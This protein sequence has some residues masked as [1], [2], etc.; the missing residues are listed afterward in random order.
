MIEYLA[1]AFLLASLA[2]KDIVKLR[3]L[4]IVSA[5]LYT[6]AFYTV[7]SLVITNLAIIGFHS[8]R[9]FA[10]RPNWRTLPEGY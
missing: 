1:L 4:G 5:C 10:D 7:P 6:L 9:L 2:N 3:I 8:W